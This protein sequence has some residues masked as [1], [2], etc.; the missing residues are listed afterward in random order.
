MLC[1]VLRCSLNS[2]VLSSF[3]LHRSQK[4]G[5]MSGDSSFMREMALHDIKIDAIT[6]ALD[7][8]TLATLAGIEVK[9]WKELLEKAVKTQ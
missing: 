4:G 3:V 5:S 9:G 7:G 8:K 1:F 2:S 6:L